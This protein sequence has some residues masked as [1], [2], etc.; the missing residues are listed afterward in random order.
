M[1]KTIFNQNYTNYRVILIDD[2]SSGKTESMIKS[3]ISD[4]DK[5][6]RVTAIFNDKKEF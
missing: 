1:L 6:G 5:F 3:F 2:H 4:N